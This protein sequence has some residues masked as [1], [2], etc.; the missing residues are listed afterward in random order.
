M[1]T[2]QQTDFFFSLGV[3]HFQI[4]DKMYHFVQGKWN[5]EIYGTAH[6]IDLLRERE[7]QKLIRDID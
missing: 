6:G 5:E 1:R 7:E 4:E 3:L 2:S